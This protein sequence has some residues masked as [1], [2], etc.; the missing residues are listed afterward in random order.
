VVK[1]RCEAVRILSDFVRGLSEKLSH[2][3]PDVRFILNYV[4]AG[5]MVIPRLVVN[6][7]D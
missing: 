5:V 7:K 6:N 1:G 4:R 2:L 3:D